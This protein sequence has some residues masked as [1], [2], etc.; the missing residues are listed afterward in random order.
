MLQDDEQ[1]SQ[2]QIERIYMNGQQIQMNRVRGL[3]RLILS[4]VYLTSVGQNL[5]HDFSSSIFTGE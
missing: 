4:V 2:Y 1:Y 5:A 3:R